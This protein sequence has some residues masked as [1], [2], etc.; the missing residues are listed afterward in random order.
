MKHVFITG[1]A[2]F[3]GSH[4]VPALLA[5]DGVER[6]TVYDNFSSGKRSSLNLL[7]SDRR[8]GV[9][10]GHVQD[11]DR[12]RIALRGYDTVFHLA[13]NPDIAAAATNPRIDFDSGT[14]LTQNV[15]EAM[16]LNG[17]KKIFFTSGSG[18]YGERDEVFT[19]MSECRPISPYGAA[20]LGSEALISAYC[21]MFGLTGRVVRF[22]NVVGGGQTHGVGFDFVRKL[23]ANPRT[24]QV[25]G[26][27]TQKKCYIGVL[28]AIAAILATDRSSWVFDQS[29]RPFEVFNASTDDQMT[30]RE[31]AFA[32]ISAL[33]LDDAK[34][35]FGAADRGWNGDVP[36]VRLS[37]EKLRDLGWKPSLT[38]KEAIWDSLRSLATSPL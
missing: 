2:G 6:V 36:Q 22:A 34:I 30:V 33:N 25:L 8:F 4:L 29:L 20:K 11:M 5:R 18:V 1:G 26:D 37:S 13:A 9:I 3:I 32:A 24:L 31:I 35:E 28:D 23:R 15:L 16:R 21:S 10:L 14:V 12:V 17:A 38:S 19:E 7:S 27:G